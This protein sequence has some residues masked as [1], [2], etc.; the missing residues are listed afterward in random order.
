MGCGG[1]EPPPGVAPEDPP[2]LAVT[3]LLP[4]EVL[5]AALLTAP[6]EGNSVHSGSENCGVMF[7]VF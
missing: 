3:E 1:P 4:G 7:S 2:S 5:G 6:L